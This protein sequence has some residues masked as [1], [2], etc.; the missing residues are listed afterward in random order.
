MDKNVK[1][2]IDNRKNVIFTTYDIKDEKMLKKIDG[3]FDKI[4]SFGEK[5]GDVNEFET[6]FAAS[7]LNQEYMDLFTGIATS[8][9]SKQAVGQVAASMAGGI[10]EGA[11]RS[12]LG[13]VIPTRAAVH[14]EAHDALQKVPVLGDA[15]DI[16]QKAGYA[17]HLGK[18]FGV[19]KKKKKDGGSAEK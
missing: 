5:C 12:A 13:G 8:F 7:P 16:G 1:M 6:K 18:L 11:A 15:M 14:Q 19:G 10:V 3:L 2:S 17:V 9:A 4:N